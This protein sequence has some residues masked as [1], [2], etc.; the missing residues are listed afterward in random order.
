MGSWEHGPRGG[1]DRNLIEKG[2]NDGWP[3]VS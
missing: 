2:A 1:D 3:V